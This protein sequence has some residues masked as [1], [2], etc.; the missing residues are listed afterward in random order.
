MQIFENYRKISIWLRKYHIRIKFLLFTPYNHF[1][2]QCKTLEYW[3][4]HNTMHIAQCPTFGCVR[5]FWTWSLVKQSQ[6]IDD[7]IFRLFR[8]INHS[9][10]YILNSVHSIVWNEIMYS[11]VKYFG[12]ILGHMICHYVTEEHILDNLFIF[13]KLL[14]HTQF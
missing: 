13:R 11:Q 5:S 3:N 14:M 1:S 8:S 7:R 9:A 4:L 2:M 10:N 6:L 12:C